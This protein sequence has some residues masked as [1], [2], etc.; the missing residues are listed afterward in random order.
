MPVSERSR[1]GGHVE[2]LLDGKATVFPT[3]TCAHCQR[4]F[5]KPRGLEDAGWC[6]RCFKPLCLKCGA[7]DICMPWEQ[8][9][10]RLEARAR[11]RRSIEAAIA[12]L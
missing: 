3:F 7:V 10:E 12:R 6:Q 2:I 1:E 9:M 8:Q 4:I 5:R 11:A